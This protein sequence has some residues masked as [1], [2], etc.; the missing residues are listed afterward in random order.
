ML[1]FYCRKLKDPLLT[2]HCL[3]K[4][5]KWPLW[6][7]LLTTLFMLMLFATIQARVLPAEGNSKAESHSFFS[8]LRFFL[9]Q[10]HQKLRSRHFS[11]NVTFLLLS[12]LSLIV[13]NLYQGMFLGHLITNPRK[14]ADDILSLLESGQ[15]RLAIFE[16]NNRLIKTLTRPNTS[17]GEH[18]R[19]VL[20]KYPPIMY[21]S[22]ESNLQVSY[23]LLL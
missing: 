15:Y 2:Q 16:A 19:K 17:I 11:R 4:V 12:Y 8:F 22:Q 13:L 20:A 14:P 10:A 18:Y 6:A 5:F 9:Q 21:S 7:V 3:L 1:Y 23:C